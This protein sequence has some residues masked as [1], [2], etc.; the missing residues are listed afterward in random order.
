ML[1][2]CS[3]QKSCSLTLKALHNFNKLNTQLIPAFN[4]I[5]YKSK[6]RALKQHLHDT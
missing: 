1:F 3:C 6:D 4:I 5:Y 2:H